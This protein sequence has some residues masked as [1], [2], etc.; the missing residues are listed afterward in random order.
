VRHASSRRALPD[1]NTDL[2]HILNAASAIAAIV[3]VV[4]QLVDRRRRP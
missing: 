3:S 4:Y 1:V 2:S